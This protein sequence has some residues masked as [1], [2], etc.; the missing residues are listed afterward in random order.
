MGALLLQHLTL[1]DGCVGALPFY[2]VISGFVF[3]TAANP[4]VQACRG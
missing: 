3:A 1:D 2:D 4:N